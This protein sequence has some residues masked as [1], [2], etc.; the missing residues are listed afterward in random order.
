MAYNDW[1]RARD[2]CEAQIITSLQSRQR[3]RL[4]V[5]HLPRELNR[6]AESCATQL[7]E[8][9]SALARYDDELS[10]MLTDAIQ[11]RARMQRFLEE[12]DLARTL[13]AT[14]GGNGREGSGEENVGRRALNDADRSIQRASA[15]QA[16]VDSVVQI[17]K[18]C[19]Q[20]LAGE[21]AFEGVLDSE[22]IRLH[23]A[24]NTAR[25]E[26]RRRLAREIHDGPAQVMANAIFGVEIAEQ[27]SRRTP[28]QVGDEL[29]NLRILLRDGVAEVR[30]FMFDLRPTMLEDQ[31]IVPTLRKYVEDFNRFF[32]KQVDLETEID[33]K[34]LQPD[35]ELAIFRTVQEALQNFQKYAATEK[36]SVRLRGT[37][38]HFEVVIADCGA[39]FDPDKVRARA[40]GGSGLKGMRDRAMLIG[41]ELSVTSEQGNGTQ[42]QLGLEK[43]SP[44]E[45]R[46]RT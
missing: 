46:E 28:D 9:E 15:L 33:G 43:R 45:V 14:D 41:A 35:E 44:S 21:H 19:T 3:A 23:L 5:E 34:L 2:G 17:V 18:H 39:G 7:E 8:A 4:P 32:G 30:R 22:D 36:A 40:S 20:Q 31:G 25:E 42:I 6:I 13:G 12:F 29:K 37:S 16:N 1:G 24:I 11:E 26:E 27:V 38:E 10:R